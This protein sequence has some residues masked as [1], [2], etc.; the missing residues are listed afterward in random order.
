MTSGT[1]RPE[2]APD[3]GQLDVRGGGRETSRGGPPG[4]PV[5]SFDATYH[6]IVPNQRIVFTYDLHLDALGAALE[7]EVV[8]ASRR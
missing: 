4:G 8:T 2:W 7:P 5:H 1:R 6:D 3:Q